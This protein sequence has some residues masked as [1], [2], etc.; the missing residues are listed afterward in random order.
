MNV[1]SE[2]Q[3]YVMHGVDADVGRVE[4][5]Y[6]DDQH[7]VVRHLVADSR[8]WLR[9]KRILPASDFSTASRPALRVARELAHALK[10]QLTGHKTDAVYRRYA[11][12][13]ESDLR[14]AGTKLAA[15]LGTAATASLS[16]N[17][18]DTS[19]TVQKG[20]SLNP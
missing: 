14:E 5:I 6:F 4:D 1:L 9:D 8:H 18:G 11:I 15:A 17:L 3:R 2:L 10:A 7:W 12:V 16:D 13:A 19:V 20:R